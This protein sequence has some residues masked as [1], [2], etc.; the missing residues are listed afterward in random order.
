M[1]ISLEVRDSSSFAKQPFVG[2]DESE[3]VSNYT[4]KFLL[5]FPSEPKWFLL[6][7]LSKV[8]HVK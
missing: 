5:V 3:S 4:Q 8:V 1:K 6:Q 7:D 2:A